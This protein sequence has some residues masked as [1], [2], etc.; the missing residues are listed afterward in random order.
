M[1]IF[2]LRAK[3]NENA[4]YLMTWKIKFQD[5]Q[6]RKIDQG[7]RVSIIT[8]TKMLKYTQWTTVCSSL[9]NPCTI[10]CSSTIKRLAGKLYSYHT[11]ISPFE[12]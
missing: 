8:K 12:L 10:H 11:S 2:F 9:N 5:L 7:S 6:F 4:I 3:K 1:Y